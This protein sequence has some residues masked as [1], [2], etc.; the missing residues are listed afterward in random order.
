MKL[1]PQPK[2]VI[3]FDGFLRTKAVRFNHFYLDSRV[4]KAV[5][6]LPQSEEGV[7]LEISVTGDEGEGYSMEICTDG[8]SV[9]AD[10]SAGAF[11]A[12]QT[13]RQLFTQEKVPCMHLED[14]PDFPYRGFYH[15]VTRGKVPTMETLKK[16]VD[17]MAY[18]KLNSLQLYVEHT[19]EFEECKDIN[20]ICGCLT[21]SD[22]IELG[23]YCQDNFIDFIPSMSTFGHMYE[24]LQQPKYQHLRIQEDDAHAPMVWYSRMKHHTIDPQNPESFPLVQSMIDQYAPCFASEW[25]NIC[26][27]ETF[28]LQ[29]SAETPEQAAQLY[30]D[31]IKKIIHH[32]QNKF[33]KVM[34][35]ADFFWEWNY[36]QAIDMMP[37]DICFLNWWYWKNPKEANFALFHKTNR[38]QIVCPGT[39]TWNRFC[40]DVATEEENICQLAELGKKYSAVGVLNTNWGDHGN[41]CSLELAMYGMVLGAEKSWSVDTPVDDAFYDRVD[42]LLYENQNGIRLLKAVSALQDR[43]DWLDLDQAYSRSRFGIT[44]WEKK[45][46]PIDLAKVQ[47]DYQAIVEELAS[48]SWKNDEYRQEMLIAAEGVCVV[49]EL[50]EKMRGN[51]PKRITDTHRW[52]E[53]YKA[54]W[55]E[56]N[57]ASELYRIEELLAYC[58]GV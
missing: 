40:E 48:Q 30:V 29:Q 28:D 20:P 3:L 26:G 36:P 54:K 58:E 37:E 47:A 11:Y 34:M 51:D 8:I 7:L 46:L 22:M 41:P 14:K 16:L 12:I 49:A 57:Q 45:N 52:L 18:Y 33:R 31:F 39:S 17:D 38:P 44:D 19:F 4:I 32:T 43:V 23:Q 6:K 10:S 53:K 24:V 9:F 21:K 42:A 27:D 5:E 15:D 35:W 13:L 25:F 55:L 50:I 2:E 1:I 56:K